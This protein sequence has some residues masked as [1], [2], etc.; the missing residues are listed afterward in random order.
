MAKKTPQGNH[1]EYHIVN[2]GTFIH[3]IEHIEHFHGRLE[4]EDAG[5]EIADALLPIF[6]DDRM[7]AEQYLSQ[8]ENAPSTEITRITNRW[9]KD[10]KIDAKKKHKPLWEVLNG[11]GIYD[12]SLSNWNDQLD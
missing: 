2:R 7:A 4:K 5:T 12:K 1:V 6:K 3:N 10:G 9:V 8:V 11:N